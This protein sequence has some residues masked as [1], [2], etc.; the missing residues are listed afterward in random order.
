MKL[1]LEPNRFVMKFLKVWQRILNADDIINAADLLKR[2][3]I[4]V[5]WFIMLGAPAETRETVIET[6]NT[7]G[8]VAS[9]WDLVFVSTG[10]RVYN[11]APVADEIM[12]NNKSCTDDN[13]LHPVKIEPV[14]ISLEDIHSIAKE[15]SFRFPTFISMKKN[16]NRRMASYHWAI[17]Y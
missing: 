7:I 12:K 15:F 8:K 17:F 16:N 3:K 6:L 5:T 13:F 1:I 11:G 10:I 2:K 9:K 14:K 4:P